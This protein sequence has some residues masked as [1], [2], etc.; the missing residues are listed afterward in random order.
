MQTM[1]EGFLEVEEGDIHPQSLIMEFRWVSEWFKRAI[2][3]SKKESNKDKIFIADRSPCS[4]IH[5]SKD[6]WC[7]RECIGLQLKALSEKGVHVRTVY[8]RANEEVVWKR[9][10]ERLV[11]EPLRMK[12]N[13]WSREWLTT[14][15]KFYEEYSWDYIIEN[16]GEIV[17]MYDGFCRLIEKIV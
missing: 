16:D 6:G 1:D 2:Q 17:D 15:M 11:K 8:I 10:S 9:V 12:F 3:L 4:A 5:Y 14:T 7:M 13:E